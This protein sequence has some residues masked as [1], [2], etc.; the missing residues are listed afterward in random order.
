MIHKLNALDKKVVFS[1]IAFSFFGSACAQYKF[2]FSQGVITESFEMSHVE[3]LTTQVTPQVD[4]LWVIDDSGSM[5]NPQI[6][7]QSAFEGFSKKYLQ[8]GK[9]WD[10]RTAAISTG[11]YGTNPA[12]SISKLLPPTSITSTLTP[13]NAILEVKS[14][15]TP[16][17]WIQFG[18]SFIEIVNK[19]T[20]GMGT[21]SAPA[22]LKKLIEQNEERSV[23]SGVNP[24]ASC[25]FR[26]KSN[27]VIVF[28]SDE[29]DNLCIGKTAGQPYFNEYKPSC[30]EN[31]LAKQALDRLY[32]SRN[33]ST[34][35]NRSY[36]SVAIT[37]VATPQNRPK[38]VANNFFPGNQSY[39]DWIALIKSDVRNPV[40]AQSKVENIYSNDYATIL[41]SLGGAVEKVS[42]TVKEVYEFSLQKS[43]AASIVQVVLESKLDGSSL[44]LSV[45]SYQVT[46]SKLQVVKERLP[47]GFNAANY[48]L[49]VSYIPELT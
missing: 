40:G 41:D 37:D 16:E 30:N 19:G 13:K 17:G 18:K 33:G 43:P 44:T 45:D 35:A 24:D 11:A 10:L 7:L 8:G 48:L 3:T 31:T 47:S 39:D 15:T 34:G 12:I 2:D 27:W 49:K 42:T 14:V 46:G 20:V 32:D 22:S 21:E 23:C 38:D 25:F 26:A 1:A 5:S 36:F 9:P 29:E 28:V 6:K 4:L